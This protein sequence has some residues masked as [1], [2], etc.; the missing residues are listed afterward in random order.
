M[1]LLK[2]CRRKYSVRERRYRVHKG[3]EVM[4]EAYT[5]GKVWTKTF[6][7]HHKLYETRVN[8]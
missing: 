4:N 8:C 3:I 5:S 2:T 6:L 1:E 7:C